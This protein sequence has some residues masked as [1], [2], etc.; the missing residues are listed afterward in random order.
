MRQCAC[1]SALP[2][3]RAG[4]LADVGSLGQPARARCAGHRRGSDARRDRAAARRRGKTWVRGPRPP[5]RRG[6]RPPHGCRPPGL[7]SRLRP[8]A[9]PGQAGRRGA[10][11]AAPRRLL[12]A[13]RAA[14]AAGAALGF[15]TAAAATTYVT[16]QPPAPG[17][18]W[19]YTNPQRTQGFWDICPR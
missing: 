1:L 10:G 3:D 11:L 8:V 12:V 13:P 18:C 17:Y 9:G 16:S 15:V 19:Y 14:V 7:P 4:G 2:C 6:G 5:G